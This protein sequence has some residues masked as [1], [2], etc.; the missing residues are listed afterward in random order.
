MLV[1]G[2]RVLPALEPGLQEGAQGVFA[3]R[4]HLGEQVF[5]EAAGVLDRLGIGGLPLA[6]DDLAAFAGVVIASYTLS[7]GTRAPSIIRLISPSD[8]EPGHQQEHFLVRP[9]VG[10]QGVPLLQHV[11]Q[12]DL[13]GS[14][15]EQSSR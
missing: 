11:V 9:A 14:P 13:A 6:D 1:A 2:Q 7:S 15:C 4:P 8:E 5:A 3:V 12:D 10:T